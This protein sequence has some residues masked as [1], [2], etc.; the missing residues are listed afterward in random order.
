MTSIGIMHR[1]AWWSFTFLAAISLIVWL[2][3]AGLEIRQNLLSDWW[4][5]YGATI[6]AGKHSVGTRTEIGF[7]SDVGFFSLYVQ[8]YSFTQLPPGRHGFR[9][10]LP[11]M[12]VRHRTTVSA[13]NRDRGYWSRPLVQPLGW[14]LEDYRPLERYL[15]EGVAIQ[16]SY[17]PDAEENPMGHRTTL[18]VQVPARMTTITLGV[19]PT[20]WYGTYLVRRRRW[21][22]IIAGACAGCGYDL[23]ASPDRCPECGAPRHHPR[24][25]RRARANNVSTNKIDLA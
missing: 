6:P 5:W 15:P 22:A 18:L 10:D 8:R 20:I 3:S 11:E 13:P 17:W 24:V 19:L 4:D 7:Y 1:K 25:S 21:R 12:G 9:P 23:R 16:T 14:A 2:G